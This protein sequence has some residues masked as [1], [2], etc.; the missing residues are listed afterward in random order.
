MKEPVNNVHENGW[1]FD[2]SVIVAVYKVEQFLRECIESVIHQDFGFEKIQLILVDDGS[3]DKSGRICDDYAVKYPRNIKVIHKKNGGVSSAR[4]IGL[5]HAE[6]R[7][8]DFL[9]SDDKLSLNAMSEVFRFFNTHEEEIDVVS[10]PIYFF[11]A[12]SGSHILNKKFEQGSRVIDLDA[13]PLLVQ[14]QV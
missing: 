13:E 6:G 10:I 4:N 8:I 11:D 12:A 3:T 14:L 5:K 2:F 9:D 1:P 7:Y